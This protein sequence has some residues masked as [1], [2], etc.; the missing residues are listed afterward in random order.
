MLRIENLHGLV[1]DDVRGADH[2]ALVT[3]DAD[4]LG[5]FAR[6][7]HHQALDVQDDV[8]DILHDAGNGGNLM[9]HALNLDAR[10]G[11]AFE[12]RQQN[13]P[14]AVADGDTEAA[15]KRLG[16]KLAVGVG[17]RATVGGDAVG[18]FQTP[19]TNSHS[20]YPLYIV[21]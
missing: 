7:L 6:I 16:G 21:I 15:F 5:V 8:G 20:L 10:D 11:A 17:Q 1:G 9:L 19:P 4:G 3:V 12:T 14:Q 13:S 18:Q 2:A